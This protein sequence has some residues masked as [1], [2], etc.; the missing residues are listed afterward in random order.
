VMSGGG[1]MVELYN[2]SWFIGL[3]IA[4]LAYWLLMKGQV[5]DGA[6]A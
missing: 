1:I 3:G 4:G 5:E 2:F 6:Q